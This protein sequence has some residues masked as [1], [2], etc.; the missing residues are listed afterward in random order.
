[1]IVLCEKCKKETTQWVSAQHR[2]G[3]K[4]TIVARCHGQEDRVSMNTDG[5]LRNWART[6]RKLIM[7]KGDQ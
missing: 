7:F 2:T 3:N 4:T 6:D 5:Y 1:M